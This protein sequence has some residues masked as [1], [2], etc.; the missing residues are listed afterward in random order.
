MLTLVEANAAAVPLAADAVSQ[1]PPD[2][3]AVATVKANEPPPAFEIESGRVL[4]GDCCCTNENV[5]ELGLTL[6]LGWP[7]PVTESVM[8]T[9]RVDGFAFGAVIVIVP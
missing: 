7:A 2:V 8:A 1:R 4:A 6:R 5:I 3:V 9:V